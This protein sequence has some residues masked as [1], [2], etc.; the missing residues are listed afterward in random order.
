MIFIRG[1]AESPPD[2][3]HVKRGRCHAPLFFGSN[4]AAAEGRTF[5]YERPQSPPQFFAGDLCGGGWF[6]PSEKWFLP[7]LQPSKEKRDKRGIYVIPVYLYAGG[8]D[9]KK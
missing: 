6:C 8:N 2:H 1:N 5:L 7:F 3:P 4:G 9:S